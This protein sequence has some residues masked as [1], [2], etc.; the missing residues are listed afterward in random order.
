MSDWRTEQFRI[1]RLLGRIIVRV[2]ATLTLGRMPSFVSTSAVVLDEGM[3]LVVI[4]PIRNEAVLPGGHLKWDEDPRDAVVREVQEE[5]G[6]L[7]RPSGIVG[8]FSGEK[9]A[10]ERGIVRVIYHAEPPNGDLRSSPEG[11]ARWMSLDEL[12][13]SS[14]RDSAILR[15]HL[16]QLSQEHGVGT[17]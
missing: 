14:S 16:D 11:E 2:A 17:R 4:D 13:A 10:G 3:V 8:V 15:V 12:V 9:W 1:A 6:L 7:I 5:T